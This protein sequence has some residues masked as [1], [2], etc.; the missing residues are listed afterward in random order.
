MN[1]ESILL[2]EINQF[3]LLTREEEIELAKLV[4][5]GDQAARDKLIT[6][7]LRLCY[8]V[9]KRYK[10]QGVDFMDL[11]SSAVNGLIRA[12]DK[13]DYTQ[14]MFSTYAVYW[15][16]TEIERAIRENK[17][18][19]T[20]PYQ[21][22]NLRYKVKQFQDKYLQ[23]HNEMPNLE[24]ISK[25][26]DITMERLVQILRATDVIASLDAP[27]GSDNEGVLTDLI[28]DDNIDIDDA[29]ERKELS[30]I[31]RE[32]L[33]TLTEEERTIIILRFGFED[34]TQWSLQAIG[35]YLGLS[36]QRVNQKEEKILAKLRKPQKSGSIKDYL[37]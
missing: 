20:L 9:S 18:I 24:T 32:G 4:K 22:N 33:E 23:E 1:S 31:L 13:Y 21:V 26:L 14:S 35:D 10:N 34:G 2:K 16:K 27:I 37:K 25:E 28:V 8:H 29:L 7:N 17:S 19:I 3:P 11:Y 15:C 6:H 30:N 5:A 12:I 36:K